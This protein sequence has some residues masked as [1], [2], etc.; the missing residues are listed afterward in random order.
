MSE[1][2]GT[3]GSSVKAVSK[4]KEVQSSPQPAPVEAAVPPS[5][6]AD[7]GIS[8]G[9]VSRAMVIFHFRR[10]VAKVICHPLG[11]LYLPYQLVAGPD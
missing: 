10:C 5:A 6:T 8:F 1:E 11:Q 9:M 2:S 4:I 7:T 3:L